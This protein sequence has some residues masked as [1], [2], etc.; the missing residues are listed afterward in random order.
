MARAE[1]TVTRAESR[2]VTWGFVQQQD[3]Q[4]MGLFSHQS[5]PNP[6]AYIIGSV[7]DLCW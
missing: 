1:A 4:G 3:E 2:E 7:Y 6:A 5:H